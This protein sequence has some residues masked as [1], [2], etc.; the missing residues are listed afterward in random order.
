MIKLKPYSSSILAF[1]GFILVVMGIYF[2]FMRPSVLPED[3]K[4][5][6]TNMLIVNSTIPNLP[7]WLEKVFW[8]MG[9][10]I[11]SS[12]LL[13][14]FIAFSSFRARTSGAFSIVAISGIS[15]IGF[16]AVVNFI[17]DS[18]FKWL[19]FAFTFPWIIS[20]IFYRLHK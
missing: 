6:K 4:Y 5:M 12:G 15:S 1:G 13:I 10:F 11:I 18:N 8:V 16:M 7:L 14:I 17:L 3:F 20:L 9:G 2:V 19:L